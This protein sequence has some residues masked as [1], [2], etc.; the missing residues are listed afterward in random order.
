MTLIGFKP[1]FFRPGYLCAS[2]Y[3]VSDNQS[4][5]LFKVKYGQRKGGGGGRDNEG[6]K[7]D[8]DRADRWHE[9]SLIFFKDIDI[10]VC[11]L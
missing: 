5:V 10:F 8:K 3:A 1:V 9:H 2:N 7:R 11:E 6:R 4:I